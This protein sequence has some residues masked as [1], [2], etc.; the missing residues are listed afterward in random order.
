MQVGKS[1]L[2]DQLRRGAR[3]RHRAL[4]WVSA[5]DSSSAA[6]RADDQ[7]G[8]EQRIACVPLSRAGRHA[9]VSWPNAS[10]ESRYAQSDQLCTEFRLNDE[11]R[12][13]AQNVQYERLVARRSVSRG[14]CRSSV[15]AL[16]ISSQP[17]E[18]SVAGFGEYG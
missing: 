1:R 14:W 5:T 11:V 6:L 15:P 16:V 12:K 8:F 13:T 3:R 9:A 18:D 4:V 2:A 7:D 10:R 17:G